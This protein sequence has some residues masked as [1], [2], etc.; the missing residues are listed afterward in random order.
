MRKK[1]AI[2]AATVLVAGG[3]AVAAIG[4]IAGSSSAQPATQIKVIEHAVSD[5]VV[6]TGKK[7]DS[8]GDLLTFHNKVYD[9]T[10]KTVAGKDQGTCVRESPKA[11]SWEC[12]WTTFLEGGQITVEGPFY[13]NKDSVVAVTGGTGTY[14]SATGSMDLHCFVGNDDVGRCDFTFNLT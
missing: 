6:D 13:D 14:A 8:S 12:M 2:T 3:G 7:G 10:D 11:G 9:S 1:L 5:H 4:S